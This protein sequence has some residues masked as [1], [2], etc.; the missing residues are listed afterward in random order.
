[1]EILLRLNPAMT[2]RPLKGGYVEPD[3]HAPQ[4]ILDVIEYGYK[5]PLLQI[6]P[7]FTAKYNSSALE[8]PDFVESA[9][10]DLISND[11]ATEVFEPPVIINPLSVS[12]QKSGKKRLILDLRHVNQFLY[13]CRFRCEDLS[14]A[15][16]ILSAGDFMFTFDLKSGYHHV[17][18]FPE[19]RKY[20]YLSGS[21]SIYHLRG[22]FPLAAPDFSSFLSFRL[23]SVPRLICLPNYSSPWSRNGDLKQSR[24][25]F[26]WMMV[27]EQP[28]T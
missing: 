27:S 12:I 8:Q 28:R 13:K 26:I 18:I 23:A 9:I 10:N 5:L 11:F 15:K 25:W 22:H 1:M 2:I 14:I 24:S 4:F 20:K 17:E 6:P 3:I 16:E 19:H 21:I 7:P